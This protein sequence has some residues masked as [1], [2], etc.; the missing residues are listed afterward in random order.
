MK[1]TATY[2]DPL[3]DCQTHNVHASMLLP[4]SAFASQ[5]AYGVVKHESALQLALEVSCVHCRAC[6]SLWQPYML[7]TA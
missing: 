4:C 7:N 2:R 1:G 6:G 3:P 5:A